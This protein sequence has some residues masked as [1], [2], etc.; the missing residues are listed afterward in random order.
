[1][2]Y[3]ITGTPLIT[4]LVIAGNFLHCFLSQCCCVIV[5]HADTSADYFTAAGLCAGNTITVHCIDY[6]CNP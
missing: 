6:F 2:T 5:I 1:M 4:S 3:L